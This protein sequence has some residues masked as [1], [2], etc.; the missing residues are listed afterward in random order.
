MSTKG[1]PGIRARTT[2][3]EIA[4]AGKPN[5][6]VVSSLPST[7]GDKDRAQR[8]LTYGQ[9]RQQIEAEHPDDPRHYGA[10]KIARLEAEWKAS[11]PWVRWAAVISDA[12]CASSSVP[13]H[14]KHAVRDAMDALPI[15]R[16]VQTEEGVTLRYNT[17]LEGQ[18]VRKVDA[19]DGTTQ[20]IVTT[21]RYTDAVVSESSGRRG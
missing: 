1:Q 19:P 3:T 10:A 11:H 4:A 16:V 7:E 12:I 13:L 18:A 8:P 9:L 5:P 21:R 17:C 14:Y 2:N 6:A 20:F 15:T